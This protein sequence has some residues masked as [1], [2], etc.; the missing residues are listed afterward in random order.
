MPLNEI[1]R[2]PV[3]HVALA[4]QPID[5]SDVFL[6][7]KT[8]RRVIYDRARAARPGCDDVILW[9]ERGEI[10]ESCTANVVLDLNGEL[11]TPP[12][13]CGLLGGTFR[14]WLIAQGQIVERVIPIELWR[15][16]RRMWLINSVR[17]WMEARILPEDR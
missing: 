2:P 6:Y 13:E 16:A 5:S 9:N 3:Q 1:A 15:A 7:H 10:T 17:K 14:A 12:L 8:S 11:I 4:Q